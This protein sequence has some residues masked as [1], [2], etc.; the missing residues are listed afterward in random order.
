MKGEGV[1][2]VE[3]RRCRNKPTIDT[4]RLPG[5]LPYMRTH[6]EAFEK[7]QRAIADK[8]QLG[9]NQGMPLRATARAI[10]VSYASLQRYIKKFG[11]TRPPVIKAP[12][13]ADER[14]AAR[15]AALSKRFPG[16][17]NYLGKESLA[18]TAKRYSISRQRVWQ[19]ATELDIEPGSSRVVY[20]INPQLS[21]KENARKLGVSVRQL[22]DYLRRNDIK[23]EFPSSYGE[24][25]RA[26]AQARQRKKLV[27]AF[28]AD[29]ELRFAV[30][31]RRMGWV[32]EANGGKLSDAGALV[33]SLVKIGVLEKVRYGVY[34]IAP[35]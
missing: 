12:P 15:L 27:T 28:G 4:T 18:A 25:V 7:K 17:E 22:Y 23:V 2:R 31:V 29:T 21:V 16:I 26:S 33:Q 35:A 13:D 9:L 10:N 14:R 24:T 5:Y 32:D 30:L 3:R 8:I 11:L 6:S 34:R 19:L 1:P 20:D